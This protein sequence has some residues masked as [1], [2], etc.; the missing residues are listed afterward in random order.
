MTN[1]AFEVIGS[2][3]KVRGAST[4]K[5]LICSFALEYFGQQSSYLAWRLFMIMR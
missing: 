2:K 3:V 1:I 5:K 4:S